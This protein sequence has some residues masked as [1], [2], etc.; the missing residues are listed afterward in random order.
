MYL[1]HVHSSLRDMV[2][3]Y[4]RAVVQRFFLQNINDYC[5]CKD[6]IK[7]IEINKI[8]KNIDKIRMKNRYQTVYLPTVNSTYNLQVYIIVLIV[9]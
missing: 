7:F 1:K 9:S 4:W 8:T 6:K 3:T 5:T 2:K